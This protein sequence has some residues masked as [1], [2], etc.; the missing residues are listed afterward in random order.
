MG[1]LDRLLRAAPA[2]PAAPAP[3][4]A[5]R[6]ADLVQAAPEAKPK[7][8]VTSRAGSSYVVLPDGTTQRTKAASEW[9]PDHQDSGQ[10]EASK[11]T[12]YLRPESAA[13]AQQAYASGR[14]PMS[15][16]RLSKLEVVD[17]RPVMMIMQFERLPAAAGSTLP[18]K[19]VRE[20]GYAAAPLEFSQSPQAGL[21]P[22]EFFQDG[23]FHLG[24]DITEVR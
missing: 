2:P 6:V 7:A 12:F 19:P 24:S 17:G 5:D 9:H 8:F 1:V 15:G 4:R 18:G 22:L 11:A 13:M 20:L 23:K 10:K 14:S 21:S 16:Q 3:A